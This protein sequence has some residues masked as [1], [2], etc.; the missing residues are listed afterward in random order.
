MHPIL[1]E[2]SFLLQIHFTCKEVLL[3]SFSIYKKI[4][5]YMIWKKSFFLNNSPTYI[6][7]HNIYTSERATI[8][9]TTKHEQLQAKL[10]WAFSHT[11]FSLPFLSFTSA[12]LLS[13]LLF[14]FSS[15]TYIM[16]LW[17]F[18]LQNPRFFLFFCHCRR[19][20]NP[21]HAHKC[22]RTKEEELSILDFFFFSESRADD[23][24]MSIFSLCYSQQK[25]TFSSIYLLHISWLK[26]HKKGM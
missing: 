19:K 13:L 21:S 17:F 14:W 18:F 15:L 9:T 7:I 16:I 8:S 25:N 23:S 11:I 20:M 4:L 24:F 22:N 1:I 3:I 2:I 12:L 10:S 26:L 6:S 5:M